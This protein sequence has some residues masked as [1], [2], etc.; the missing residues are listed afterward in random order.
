MRR[1]LDLLTA[2]IS[3]FVHAKVYNKGSIIE[4]V[5]TRRNKVRVLLRGELAVF[6]PINYKS[7]KNCLKFIENKKVNMVLLQS[8]HNIANMG[9]HFDSEEPDLNT[10]IESLNPEEL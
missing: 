7:Y 8:L 3:K 9:V 10:L 6:E 1:D 5:A 4:S 2:V